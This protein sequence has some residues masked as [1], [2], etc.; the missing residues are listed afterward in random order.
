MLNCLQV[1][2]ESG[3]SGS[4]RPNLTQMTISKDTR[5]YSL[6]NVLP[7]KKV[8]TTMWYFHLSLKRLFDDCYGNG[9]SLCFRAPSN[10]CENCHSE[11][12]KHSW[13]SLKVLWLTERNTWCVNWRSQYTDLNKLPEN[14]T[15]SSMIPLHLL[16]LKKILLIDVYIWRSV[17]VSL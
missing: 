16:N 15:L 8:L 12:K 5:P 6:P 13:I 10:G 3:A 11:W 9:S 2:N 7:R 1:I 17:E 4:S 14:S